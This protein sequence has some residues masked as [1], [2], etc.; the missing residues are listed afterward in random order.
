V[1]FPGIALPQPAP[2]CARP[3]TAGDGRQRPRA[4][5]PREDRCRRGAGPSLVKRRVS[6]H[7]TCLD[8]ARWRIDDQHAPKARK[9]RCRRGAGICQASVSACPNRFNVAQWRVEVARTLEGQGE[10]LP[11]M[12]SGPG[13]VLLRPTA[14]DA[15]SEADV[16][17]PTLD[18]SWT[19]GGT[20]LEPSCPACG[21]ADMQKGGGPSLPHREGVPASQSQGAA[22]DAP[23]QC[24]TLGLGQQSKAACWQTCSRW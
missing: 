22:A 23:A 10:P 13:S 12:G 17:D 8:V 6:L 4:A 1:P 21:T 7:P 15:R 2:P 20:I 3:R 24:S 16:K 5:R 18:K 14:Q 19:P 9:D 11:G